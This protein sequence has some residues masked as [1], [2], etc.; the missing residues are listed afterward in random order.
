MLLIPKQKVFLGLAWFS[1]ATGLAAAPQATADR[2][3]DKTQEYH[4]LVNRYCVHCH[5]A[6]TNTPAASPV[7]L[8]SPSFDDVGSN[9]ATWERVIRKLNIG[10]MPPPGNPRPDAGVLED[11]S[12]WLAAR[13]DANTAS[14]PG[15]FPLHRLN[16][17]EYA[18]AIRDLLSLS[19]DPASMLPADSASSGFDNVS[20][21]LKTSPLLLERYLAVGLR[22]AALAVGDRT[23]GPETT[24]YPPRVPRGK[25]ST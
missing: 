25:P 14:N 8:D 21:A 17:A 15:R 20:D 16:R 1:L 4:A 6:G 24:I 2:S 18:D 11:F 3:R 9:A 12:S 7:F 19:L 22:V 23:M 13:L 5:N 10:A